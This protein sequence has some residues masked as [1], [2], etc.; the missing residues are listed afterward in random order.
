MQRIFDFL[1]R[2]GQGAVAIAL[3]A[4]GVL[5]LQTAL[6]TIQPPDRRDAGLPPR[7]VRVVEARTV[8]LRPWVRGHGVASPRNTWRAVSEINARVV[9]IH[10][11]LRNG[12]LI[13][14]GALLVELDTTELKLALKR[15]EAQIAQLEAQKRRLEIQERNDRA[16]LEIEE[17]A[18][19]LA[20]TDLARQ[21]ELL[22]KGTV[23]QKTVDAAEQALLASR[24]K[25]QQ[26][27]SS[28]AVLPA[29]Q[30]ELDASID[31]Q[32]ATKKQTELDLKKARIVAPFRGRATQVAVEAQQFVRTGEVLLALDDISVAEVTARVPV[33]RL[34]PLMSVLDDAAAD[35]TLTTAQRLERRRQ[36]LEVKVRLR[37][38]PL[39]YEWDATFTRVEDGLDSKTRTVGMIVAVDDPYRGVDTTPRPPLAK[40]MFVEVLLRTK[41]AADK[42]VVPRSAVYQR[43]IRVVGEGDVLEVAP[44]A[45]DYVLDELAILRAGPPAGTRVLATDVVP[46]VVGMRLAPQLDEALTRRLER[47]IERG[48]YARTDQPVAAGDDK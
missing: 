25:V 22:G 32:E 19:K 9:R 40:G 31:V 45:V 15:T 46:A 28:L 12:A 17:R 26:L 4:G 13:D 20:E 41:K 35:V 39:V 16:T 29:Q 1:K 2:L 36:G 11:Q 47:L 42:L 38:D 3:I 21:R 10:P 8:K 23:P 37:L 43:R 6:A 33:D 48:P 34:R 44:V 7:P 24:T 18:Y 5:A 14:A 30:E 27:K